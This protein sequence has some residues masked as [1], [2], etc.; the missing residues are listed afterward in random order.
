MLGGVQRIMIVGDPASGKSTF[1]L[2]LSTKLNLPLFHTDL[3]RYTASGYRR[4]N[5]E[6]RQLLSE[7][8]EQ[9]QWVIEGNI[10]SADPC[11]RVKKAQAIFL[12]DF[13]KLVT[14]F[15]LLVR[16]FK[17]AFCGYQRLGSPS[18][19]D[20]SLAWPYYAPYILRRF[21]KRKSALRAEVA[22]YPSK[23][24]YVFSSLRGATEF[25]SKIA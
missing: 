22:K 4:S 3:I 19:K 15:R 1:G 14:L 17:T 21:P 23:L 20:I 5:A 25:L 7:W 11:E 16:W 2:A 12:F 18:G 24:L 6:V 10:L 8:L 9:E 13:P